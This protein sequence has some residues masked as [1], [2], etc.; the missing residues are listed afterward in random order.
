MEPRYFCAWAT[1]AEIRGRGANGGFVTALLISALETGFIDLALVVEKKSVYEGVPVLTDDPERV[2]GS[3]GSLHGVPLN[4]A[5]YLLECAPGKRVGLPTKPCDARGIIELAK[6]QQIALDQVY[7]IGLNCGGT[8]HPLRMRELVAE[9]YGIDPDSVQGEEI[10][11]GKL[12]IRYE[13][14]GGAQAERGFSIDEL[15]Q[16]GLGRRDACKTCTTKIPVMADLACGNW[17]VPKGEEKTFVEVLTDKGAA[18]LE[19][20]LNQGAIEVEDATEQGSALR[21]R[22]ELAMQELAA[23]W[24]DELDLLADTPPAERLTFYTEQLQRCIHCGACRTVCPICACDD[25]AK[26]LDLHDEKD[27]YAISL[28]NLVRILHLMD[29]CIHCGQCEEVCPV[30]I[31]LTLI[32]RRFSE[33][34]QAILDYKPGMDVTE[35]PPFQETTLRW[36]AAATREESEEE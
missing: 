28:Y 33:R 18:I 4:L 16:Q 15:E 19:N 5:K 32:Q 13:D 14:E 3:A 22:I 7:L 31:P 12:I 26:C 10:T 20:A 24:K 11:G 25:A 29:S 6:R 34:M 35:T 2:K 8:L 9:R 21:A 36:P 23:R 27:A 1:D 17:G 30:D